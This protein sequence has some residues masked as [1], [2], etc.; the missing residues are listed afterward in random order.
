MSIIHQDIQNEE[1]DPNIYS[2]TMLKCF[3][4]IT[5]HQARS[6]LMGLESGQNV[7]S[8]SE[9]KKLTDYD[10]LKD[11]S[12]NEVKQKSIELERT[13]K[14]FKK[15]QED[16]MGGKKPE[17]LAEEYDEDYDFDDDY[18]SEKPSSIN[19][20]SLIP[21]GFFGIL[22]IFSN[23]IS[24]F[25]VFALVYFL[26]LA[27]RKMSDSDKKIKK[28]KKKVEPEEDDIEEE[29]QEEQDKEENKKSNNKKIVR[30][31]KMKKEKRRI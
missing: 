29:E 12:Q 1:P 5:D 23:Y 9:I 2:V 17:D 16:I 10:S 24:M 31:I 14:K 11:L 13:L 18:G 26:L 25:I 30:I 4:T 21:K 6:V 22:G 7:L 3:I 8:K 15:M 20:F 27:L 28:K 19:F